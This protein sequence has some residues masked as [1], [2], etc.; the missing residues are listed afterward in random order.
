MSS[1]RLGLAAA[2]I[3]GAATLL[4]AAPANADDAAL[5]CSERE[6]PPSRPGADPLLKID[7]AFYKINTVFGKLDPESQPFYKIDNAIHK[8]EDAFYKLMYKDPT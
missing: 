2:T 5:I 4:G 7:R 3:L 8:I 1:K 6:C